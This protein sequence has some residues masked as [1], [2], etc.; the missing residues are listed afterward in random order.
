MQADY[1]L[2]AE[3]HLTLHPF[4]EDALDSYGCQKMAMQL[5]VPLVRH[6]SF[7]FPNS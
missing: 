5:I 1:D 3:R 4:N 7:N 6:L 2:C